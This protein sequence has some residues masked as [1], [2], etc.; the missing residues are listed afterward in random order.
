MSD[1]APASAPANSTGL[2]D[3]VPGWLVLPGPVAVERVS[4]SQRTGTSREPKEPQRLGMTLVPPG[5]RFAWSEGS[6]GDADGGGQRA[7]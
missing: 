1:A 5:G 2:D 4:M 3:D 6:E 7:C